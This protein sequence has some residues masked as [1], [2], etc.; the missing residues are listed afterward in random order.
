VLCARLASSRRGRPCPLVGRSPR[1][2]WPRLTA[3]PLR[4]AILASLA[5]IARSR[6]RSAPPRSVRSEQAGAGLFAGRRS[7]VRAVSFSHRG[8][9]CP[10]V[11]RSPRPSWPRLTACPLRFAILASLAPIARSRAR[12]AP[13]H[14]VDRNKRVP[15]CSPD[16]SALFVPAASPRCVCC[17]SRTSPCRSSAAAA[18][19][20][21]CSAPS[22]ER[23]TAARTAAGSAWVSRSCPS[24]SLSCGGHGWLRSVKSARRRTVPRRRPSSSRAPPGGCGLHG[25]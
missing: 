16:E 24:P 22:A 18:G 17:L 3:C 10:L 9:P 5:P 19:R 8:C 21:R 4:F 11:G 6:A 14:R 2:S 12:S 15:G 1:P 13:S 7:V 20:P 23:T 25:A